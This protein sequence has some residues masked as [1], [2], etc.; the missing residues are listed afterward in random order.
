MSKK[1]IMKRTRT[2]CPNCGKKLI[3]KTLLKLYCSSCKKRYKKYQNNGKV[4]PD[5]NT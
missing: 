5:E 1:Y 4:F 2:P 3:K